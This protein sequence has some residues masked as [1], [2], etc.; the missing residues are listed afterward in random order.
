MEMLRDTQLNRVS[1]ESLTGCIKPFDGSGNVA[2]WLKKVELVARIKKIEDE[3]TL[4]PLHLEGT[5]FEVYEQMEETQ[6][7]DAAAIKRCLREAFGKDKFAAYDAF[8][9]RSWNPNE[10]VDAFLSDLRRLAGLAGIKSDEI[11]CLAFVCGLPPDVSSQLRAT[12]RIG[13]ADLQTILEIARVLMDERVQGAFA[14][15]RPMRHHV[16]D[17]RQKLKCFRCGGDHLARSCRKRVDVRCWRCDQPGHFARNCIAS[18]SSG[19]VSGRLPAPAASQ[20]E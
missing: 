14:A 2:T 10:A 1:E 8:R 7:L 17:S 15:G 18:A 20:T 16:N 9:Q 6:Q 5:A 19:N 13:E 11:I 3:P 4:I 12:A